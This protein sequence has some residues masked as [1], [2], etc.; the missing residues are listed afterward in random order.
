MISSFILDKCGYS[1]W[2]GNENIDIFFSS[3]VA[4]YD[5]LQNGLY[6]LNMNVVIN[7]L[8]IYLKSLLDKNTKGLIKILLCYGMVFGSHL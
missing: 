2:Q 5:S 3:I 4:G 6:C 8:V 7:H 1:F